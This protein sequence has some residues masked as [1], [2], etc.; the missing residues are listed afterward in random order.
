[1]SSVRLSLLSAF[2]LT[3]AV[4]FTGCSTLGTLAYFVNPN[5]IPAEFD[6]LSGKNVAV[7]CNPVVELQYSDAG[8]ARELAQ[9]VLDKQVRMGRPIR[10]QGL[11]EAAGGPAF[12]TCAGLLVYAA[13]PHL[14]APRL[15]PAPQ[16]ESGGLFGRMGS[17]LKEHF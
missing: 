1:M 16:T 7:V 3:S 12:S 2:M 17:R 4:L 11:A 8:S 14:D 13:N 10:V 15:A 9:L 6:E 5:D